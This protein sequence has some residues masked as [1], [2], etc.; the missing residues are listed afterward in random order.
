MQI[1]AFDSGDFS[2]RK[3]ADGKREIVFFTPLG[4]GVSINEKSEEKFKSAY[5]SACK[6]LAGEFK[7]PTRRVV[8]SHASLWKEIGHRKA[9]PFCDNVIK[10]LQKL[11]DMVFVSYVV[12]PPDEEKTSKL[13]VTAVQLRISLR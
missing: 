2:R 5:L 9:V 10:E 4:I 8:Y 1:V 3:K 11:I 7:V 13:V 6:K 12:L